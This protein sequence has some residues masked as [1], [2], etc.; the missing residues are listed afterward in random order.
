PDC[1]DVNASINPDVTEVL[2]GI[3]DNCNGIIDDIP[4]CQVPVNL[5]INKITSIS[6]KLKW[7]EVAEAGGYTVRYKVAN[8]NPWKYGTTYHNSKPI[9]GLLPGT[10]Y[11]WE[12]Q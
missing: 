1:N 11:V 5:S 2:N 7:H 6:A 3:D 4:V 12:V 10:V 8:T 9:G